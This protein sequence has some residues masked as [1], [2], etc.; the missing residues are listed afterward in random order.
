MTNIWGGGGLAELLLDGHEAS[1]YADAIID[2]AD[3]HNLAYFRMGGQIP[4]GWAM[5]QQGAGPAGLELMW[6]SATER[7]A[8]GATWWQI[9]YLCM[10]AETCVQHHRLEEGLAAVAEAEKLAK[11]THER[12]W[13]S[14]LARIEGELRRLV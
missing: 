10:L 7:M 12:M 13:K 5:A 1:G 8:T 3:K 14:E 6:Q 9:R 11:R 2:L 4:K